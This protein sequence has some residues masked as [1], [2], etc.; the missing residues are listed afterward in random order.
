MSYNK[1]EYLIYCICDKVVFER[2]FIKADTPLK[3][4][5]LWGK[6]F[7]FGTERLYYNIEKDKW[8]F[9]GYEDSIGIVIKEV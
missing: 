4:M 9:K 5:I 1:N 6:E 8:Y 3:A 7:T 2:K